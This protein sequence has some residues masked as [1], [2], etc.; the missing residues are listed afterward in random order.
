LRKGRLFTGHDTD[1]TERVGVVNE[2]LAELLWPGQN[3][4]GKRLKVGKP[5]SKSPWT[6]IIGVVGNVQHEQVAGAPGLDLYVSYLQVPDS[7]TYFLLR[8]KTDALSL[9]I[10]AATRA[11]WEVDPDQSTFDFMAMEQ[12]I[13]KR[14][15]QHRI[16]GTLLVVFAGLAFILAAIGI[17]GVMSYAVRQRTREIGIRMAL[18]AARSDVVRMVLGE[19]ARLVLVGGSLGLIGAF[20]LARVMSRLLYQ[21]SSTDPLTFLIGSIILAMVALVAAYLPARRA[22]SVNPMA[23]LREG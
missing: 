18:G 6:T 10:E 9:F 11:I 1:K 19:V 14:I 23:A 4:I 20:A 16:S 17:Y 7:G 8:A 15:W 21:I 22:A 12:R 5:D 2:K 3:P 13:A